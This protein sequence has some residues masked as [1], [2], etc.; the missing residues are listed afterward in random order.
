MDVW[1]GFERERARV[2]GEINRLQ[3]LAGRVCMEL[4]MAGR[5]GD[6]R[7]RGHER[8]RGCRKRGASL[9]ASATS[10]TRPDAWQSLRRIHPDI[11]LTP[12]QHTIV[13]QLQ[14]PSAP[15]KYPRKRYAHSIPHTNTQPDPGLIEHS[16]RVKNTIQRQLGGAVYRDNTP[17]AARPLS[18]LIH[19]I[20]SSK[21]AC[22]SPN[23]HAHITEFSKYS[24]KP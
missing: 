5:E 15:T 3:V 19:L 23:M 17:C 16:S 9:L 12:P 2:T 13:F 22:Q 20:H 6:R 21:Y 4:C 18:L 7:G 1:I 8:G 11:C 14:S 24:R 10:T